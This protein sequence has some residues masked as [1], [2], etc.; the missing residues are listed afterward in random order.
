MNAVVAGFKPAKGYLFKCPV[1]GV[2]LP[3]RPWKCPN[4]EQTIESYRTDMFTTV[5]VPKICLDL[6]GVVLDMLST[7]KPYLKQNF[8]VDFFPEKVTDFDFNCEMGCDRS[9]V[10]E[11][12]H[13]SNLHKDLQLYD[14]AQDAV[15]LL[16]QRC[17]VKAYT[18][19]IDDPVIVAVTNAR[20]RALGI[21]GFALPYKKPVI[22]DAHVLFDDCVG[23]HRQWASG[24]FRGLQY[25]IDHPYNQQKTMADP[26]WDRVVR[27]SSLYD[28]VVDMYR[29]FGWS[30][31]EV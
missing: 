18:G 16:R 14:K 1:C 7:L 28:G 26:I 27:V 30:L 11:A 9:I 12:F 31:P 17:L 5:D 8:G 25:L 3:D 15:N 6:H 13:D 4:C 21:G 10:Y 19:V 22:Y 24:G 23:V 29:R 20:I 2:L